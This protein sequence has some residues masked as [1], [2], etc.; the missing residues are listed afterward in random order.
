MHTTDNRRPQTAL[1]RA[2]KRSGLKQ[3]HIAA[4]L[5]GGAG[6]D[7]TALSRWLRG[8]R[9]CPSERLAEIAAVLGVPVS[10]LADDEPVAAGSR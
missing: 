7:P 2:V 3:A 10:E 1:A 4:Q 5:D 6:V 8:V 9:P